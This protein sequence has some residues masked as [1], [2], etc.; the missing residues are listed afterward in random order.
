MKF[1]VVMAVLVASAS[2]VVD[3]SKYVNIAEEGETPKYTKE[4]DSV[5]AQDSPVPSDLEVAPGSM[6]AT[7]K[8]IFAPL[9]SKKINEQRQECKKNYPSLTDETDK[10]CK[11]QCILEK[12]GFVDPTT[13]EAIV[14]PFSDAM[15]GFIAAALKKKQDPLMYQRI[16]A[17]F[18][19]C[20]SQAKTYNTELKGVTECGNP[21]YTK[22]GLCFWEMV[23]KLCSDEF[24]SFSNTDEPWKKDAA[25]PEV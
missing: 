3:E 8:A 4:Q 21:V 11:V 24:N 18:T 23:K 22:Y 12:T 7:C 20:Y 17:T 13:K 14:K 10:S 16:K 9:Q 2:A 5:N 19:W 1:A 6:S 25:K 15:D